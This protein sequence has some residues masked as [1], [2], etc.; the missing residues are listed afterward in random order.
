VVGFQSGFWIK[1]VERR[2]RRWLHM[3][4]KIPH[5]ARSTI[6]RL[7]R[8]DFAFDAYRVPEVLGAPEFQTVAKKD[9]D[10]SS[11]RIL[12]KWGRMC[13]V[14]YNLRASREGDTPTV[15]SFDDTCYDDNFFAEYE[16]DYEEIRLLHRNLAPSIE[17]YK[18]IKAAS[19]RDD[20]T[21]TEQAIEGDL[22]VLMM[23]LYSFV[24]CAVRSRQSKETGV[25]TA[26]NALGFRLSDPQP[27][28][29][30]W[31]GIICV[32][33]FAAMISFL[34]AYAI[35]L[36]FRPDS[37]DDELVEQLRY[38]PQDPVKRILWP[39]STFLYL[40]IAIAVGRMYRRS[41][42]RKDDWLHWHG[43]DIDRPY[44]KYIFAGV[45]AA[46]AGYVVLVM[47]N[48]LDR[49]IDLNT[50]ITDDAWSVLVEVL[51]LSLAW[52]MVGGIAAARAVYYRD[53]PAPQLTFW[54]RVWFVW[55]D[56]ISMGAVA[57]ISTELYT[58]LWLHFHQGIGDL[59]QIEQINTQYSFLIAILVG[60]MGALIGFYFPRRQLQQVNRDAPWTGAWRLQDAAGTPHSITLAPGGRASTDLYP[61]GKGQWSLGDDQSQVQIA[62]SSGWIDVLERRGK[63]HKKVAYR[64]GSSLYSDPTH[65]WEIEHA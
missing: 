7:R 24:V 27:T 45:L 10:D 39:I 22:E 2:V 19:P 37:F 26:L 43:D 18:R 13:C 28:P 38:I 9:F 6:A 62:W 17:R 3:W 4:A 36:Y 60:F 57:F 63:R 56:A 59:A 50:A 53:T 51:V 61:D 11:P 12:R 54:W 31:F 47:M 58:Y 40:G 20:L 34:G 23:K 16:E 15:G 44:L 30:D 25:A 14:L 48:G 64:S 33:F 55:L 35:D 29:V 52:I 8:S 5:G 1:E 46:G 42:V 21:T 49:A 32:V 41:R 65:V